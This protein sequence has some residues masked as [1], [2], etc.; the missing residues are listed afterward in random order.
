MQAT[1]M[2]ATSMQAI[3]MQDLQ[4]HVACKSSPCKITGT[5]LVVTL[6]L[7]CST[8]MHV[9]QMAC[10]EN[11]CKTELHFCSQVAAAAGTS[12]HQ[13]SVQACC[14]LAFTTP[15][16]AHA[17]ITNRQ[18]CVLKNRAATLSVPLHLPDNALVLLISLHCRAYT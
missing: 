9:R 8:C 11:G 6:L 15:V 3:S 12:V 13:D 10:G 5:S 7:Y 4:K 14:V 2:Q 1:S 18:L 16:S 17:Y